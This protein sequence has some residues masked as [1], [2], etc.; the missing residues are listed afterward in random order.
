MPAASEVLANDFTEIISALSENDRLRNSVVQLISNEPA[1]GKVTEG[2][3]RLDK[4]RGIL[5]DLVNSQ[6]NFTEAYERTQL[7]LARELSPYSSN[8]K[9]FAQNWYRRLIDTQL[10]RFYNQAVM[11]QLI[12]EGETECFVPHSSAE[13]SDSKCSMH[14]AG[15]NHDLQMLYTRLVDSYSKGKWTQVLKIPHHPNCTHV[16]TYAQL[17]STVF[18]RPLP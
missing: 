3:G 18:I 4:L 2:T 15:S 12:A 1:P 13:A 8:N 5:I 16:V 9:V 7:E 17:L 14:L 11:E 10:S 6:I